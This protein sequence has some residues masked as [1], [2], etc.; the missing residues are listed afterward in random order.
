MA[1]IKNALKGA[2]EDITH[3]GN[4]EIWHVTVERA[5]NLKD[6]DV[7]SNS[8]ALVQVNLSGFT[9][10]TKTFKNNANPRWNET[11]EFEIYPEK[12][13]DLDLEFKVMDSDMLSKD[14]LGEA[15]IGFEDMPAKLE[16]NKPMRVNLVHNKNDCGTLFFRV[17]RSHKSGQR[18]IDR[19]K[20]GDVRPHQEKPYQEL[21]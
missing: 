13:K 7:L 9:H 4:P 14:P 6:K 11:F 8:D 16:E 2:A 1:A 10:K 18:G 15:L 19:N 21:S 3:S 20:H 12:K 5:E 17:K